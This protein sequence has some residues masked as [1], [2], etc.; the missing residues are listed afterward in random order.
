MAGLPLLRE[1]SCLFAHSAYLVDG[2]EY[3]RD[4]RLI[5]LDTDLDEPGRRLA[6]GCVNAGLDEGIERAQTIV[7]DAARDDTIARLRPRSTTDHGDQPLGNALY[8]DA[9]ALENLQR[10]RTWHVKA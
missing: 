3:F 9:E 10:N 2:G 8:V 6:P 1:G 7:V 5:R 4:K